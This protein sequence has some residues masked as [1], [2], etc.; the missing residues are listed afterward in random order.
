ME[1]ENIADLSQFSIL[2]FDYEVGIYRLK[3]CENSVLLLHQWF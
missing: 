1:N 3:V 2:K